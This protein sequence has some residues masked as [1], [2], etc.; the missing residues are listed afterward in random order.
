MTMWS[1]V[2]GEATASSGLHGYAP[3]A[4]QLSHAEVPAPILQVR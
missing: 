1:L 4:N 3:R 2:T